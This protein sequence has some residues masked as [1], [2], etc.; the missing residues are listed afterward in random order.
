MAYH[1]PDFG[2]EVQADRDRTQAT[3]TGTSP[4]ARYYPARVTV[5]APKLPDGSLDVRAWLRQLDDACNT[6]VIP[7]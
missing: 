1:K 7:C 3:R 4:G 5:E 6:A 2:P